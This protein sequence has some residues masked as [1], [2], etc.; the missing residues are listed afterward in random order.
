MLGRVTVPIDPTLYAQSIV[1]ITREK[2]VSPAVTQCRYYFPTSHALSLGQ[3][4][5]VAGRRHLSAS[6]F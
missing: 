1:V 6:V 4:G 3:L 5:A 2:A